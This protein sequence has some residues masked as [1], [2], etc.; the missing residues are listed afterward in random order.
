MSTS[1][2]EIESWLRDREHC[3]I[4][5]PTHMAVVCDTFDWSDYPVYVAAKDEA[6]ARK[7]IKD[8]S[9][10]NMRRLMEV[11]SLTGKHSIA[12]QMAERRAYH[13]D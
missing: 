4:D 2:K 9:T 10:G 1:V 12:L 7:Q 5:N 13:Y 8:K 6:D 3:Y 11:Y